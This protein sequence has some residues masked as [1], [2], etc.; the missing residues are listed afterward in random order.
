MPLIRYNSKEDCFTVWRGL[1]FMAD[2]NEILSKDR[3]SAQVADRIQDDILKGGMGEGERLPSERE[4]AD[5]FGVSRIVIREGIKML[6]ERGIVQV[7]TGS[8]S[9]VTNLQP[10]ALAESMGLFL[11]QEGAPLAYL[12]EVRFTIEVEM[13]ALAARRR[14]DVDIECVAK[15]LQ[16]MHDSKDNL[17]EFV[18]ADLDF[19]I[20]LAQATQNPLFILLIKTLNPLMLDLRYKANRVKG[21]RERALHYHRQILDHIR[22]LNAADAKDEMAKHLKEADQ[23]LQQVSID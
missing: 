8:G 10:E 12:Q 5:R 17:D 20:A 18:Q 9:Y 11:Q 6:E 13:A 1:C 23:Y 3:L 4:L 15:T 7:R 14:T 21:A 16:K 19:H 2:L 22:N